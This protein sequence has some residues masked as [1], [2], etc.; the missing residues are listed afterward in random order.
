ME[1]KK[2]QRDDN[3]G[4]DEPLDQDTLSELQIDAMRERNLQKQKHHV[5]GFLTKN[6]IIKELVDRGLGTRTTLIRK[7][8]KLLE[9]KEIQCEKET[10][11]YRFSASAENLIKIAEGIKKL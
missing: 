4:L 2:L 7:F 10:G 1:E 11:A 9:L 6:Q 5:K 3:Y 8:E